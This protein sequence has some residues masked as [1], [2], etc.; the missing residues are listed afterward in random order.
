MGTRETRFTVAVLLLTS[1]FLHLA[2]ASN[3]SMTLPSTFFGTA[4]SLSANGSVALVVG[5]GKDSAV[6]RQSGLSWSTFNQEG[7]VSRLAVDGGTVSGDG[8][9]FVLAA[10]GSN[11]TQGT[12]YVYRRNGLLWTSEANLT[13]SDSAPSDYF[14]TSVSLSYN[15]SYLLVGSASKNA[16]GA[17]QTGAAYVFSRNGTKWAQQQQLLAS[18]GSAQDLFGKAV[19]L[20][21]DGSYALIG[22]PGVSQSKGAVYAF[23][24]I[25]TTWSEEQKI[26]PGYLVDNDYFGNGVKISSSGILALVSAHGKD[27]DGIVDAGAAY[28][29]TLTAGTWVDTQAITASN[30]N[31]SNAFGINNALAISDD[32]SE[33]LVGAPFRVNYDTN[34]LGAAY[35]YQYNGTGWNESAILWNPQGNMTDRFGFSVAVSANNSIAMVGAPG[36]TRAYVFYTP[37]PSASPTMTPTATLSSFYTITPNSTRSPS[38]SQSISPSI[39][40]SISW[41]ASN[42]QTGTNSRTVS[43]SPSVTKS[44][45]SISVSTSF[46]RTVSITPSFSPTPSRTRTPSVIPSGVTPSITPSWS[47]SYN[48]TSSVTPSISD[49]ASNSKS[50]SWSRTISVS[51]SF[52]RSPTL[53]RTTSRTPSFTRSPSVTVTP[54][55]QYI[56]VTASLD[57]Q[58]STE[59]SVV[60]TLEIRGTN[61]YAGCVGGTIEQTWTSASLTQMLSCNDTYI[62]AL[63]DITADPLPWLWVESVFMMYVGTTGSPLAQVVPSFP[64]VSING[65][66]TTATVAWG[67]VIQID[68]FGIGALPDLSIILTDVGREQALPCVITAT[69]SNNS[70]ACQLRYVTSS[71]LGGAAPVVVAQ[72]GGNTLSESPVLPLQL[73]FQPVYAVNT[74]HS[75]FLPL[76]GGDVMTIELPQPMWTSQEETDANLQSALAVYVGVNKSTDCTATTPTQIT[77]SS[78]GG[79]GVQLPVV[80]EI[81][82]I[83]NVSTNPPLLLSYTPPSALAITPV[84]VLVRP[85]QSNVQ[86]NLTFRAQFDSAVDLLLLRNF[87][88]SNGT[89]NRTY[90][91]NAYVICIGWNP[92]LSAFSSG[93]DTLPLVVS[94]NWDSSVF[95][96]APLG[97]AILRPSISSVAPASVTPSGILVLFG[98]NMCPTG[99]CRGPLDVHVWIGTYVCSSI[100]VVTSDVLTCTVPAV[101]TSDPSFPSFAVTVENVLGARSYS[102]IFVSFPTSGSVQPA[103]ALPSTYM[104]SDSSTPWAMDQE[105]VVSLLP[106]GDTLPYHGDIT[107]S[108]TTTTPGALLLPI[109]RT[110]LN[111]VV[112]NT[113]VRFGRVGIQTQFT[114]LTVQLIVS[115]SSVNTDLTGALSLVWTV[116]TVPLRVTMCIEP[117]TLIASQDTI[118]RWA[119]G[120]FVEGSATATSL[121]CMAAKPRWG[122]PALPPIACVASVIDS[123]G[124]AGLVQGNAAEVNVTTGIATFGSMSIA[125][126]INDVYTVLVR[127]S[128]GSILIPPTLTRTVNITGCAAGAEPAGVFCAPC[129]AGQYG[130]GGGKPC[131]G[132]PRKGAVCNDGMLHLLQGYYRPPQYA[133]QDLDS[134]SELH[135]CALPAGCVTNATTR[136]FGCASG[137]AGVL[138]G[139]CAVEDGYGRVADACVTCPPPGEAKFVVVVL[140]L[141]IVL[142]VGCVAAGKIGQE[143]PQKAGAPP[144][145][146][147]VSIALRMLLTHVQAVGSLHS[148]NASGTALYH[149]LTAWADIMSSTVLAQGPVQCALQPTYSLVFALTILAPFVAVL[150]GMAA[151]SVRFVFGCVNLRTRTV[152]PRAW[153]AAWDGAWAARRPL[154]I[155]LVV[156]QV[157]YMPIV[158]TAFTIF[159]CTSP[160]AGEQYLWADLRVACEGP[161]YIGL[162]FGAVLALLLLG[163]GFPLTLFHR[164]SHATVRSLA[165]PK[166]QRVWGFLYAG[167]RARPE[168]ESILNVGSPSRWG[169]YCRKVRRNLVWWEAA[170]LLRKAGIVLM[171]RVVHSDT[172]QVVGVIF[173][174]MGFLIAQVAMRPYTLRTFH[175]ADAASM[176]TIIITAGL[177]LLQVNNADST[178]ADSVTIIMVVINILMVLAL[179]GILYRA[180]KQEWRASKKR[181]TSWIPN[182]KGKKASEQPADL[183]PEVEPKLKRVFS[184]PKLIDNGLFKMRERTGK[185]RPW[186]AVSD[187]NAS[188]EVVVSSQIASPIFAP[189]GLPSHHMSN[190]ASPMVANPFFAAPTT[191]SPSQQGVPIALGDP[192]HPG[193][194]RKAADVSF[195]GPL[196]PRRGNRIGTQV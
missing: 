124:V 101:D 62:L 32:G 115:C 53:T 35:L 139:T 72:Y 161:V 147:T 159:D 54:N 41:S 85:F 144:K 165:S 106:A 1:A 59:S 118:P 183:E 141:V 155:L 192:L 95:S 170:V 30:A 67:N 195:G 151:L 92:A 46:S 181:R 184:L 145:T 162:Q 61:L 19:S 90:V 17:P 172:G 34:K 163:V 148:F 39:S 21:W 103:Q 112:N 149:K 164:L 123:D 51:Q 131:L 33:V 40:K 43:V 48:Q 128:V 68:A 168:K 196:Q 80:W 113:Y 105:I 166:F 111:A 49:T 26:M 81:D 93:L 75:P 6:Y 7:I 137:Y 178:E 157:T 14:G 126:R 74:T 4:V 96:S 24:R 66:G 175:L 64:S 79:H 156:C 65:A 108:L 154:A 133:A 142:L 89:C 119:V 173:M 97:Q 13:G 138:C 94:F 83:L 52:S 23:S 56:Y 78:P 171:A 91:E 20:N 152:S 76:P 188:T 99:W 109:T 73:Q 107:C 143:E 185:A 134:A 140:I 135:A 179:L 132:C 71:M 122:G 84:T 87:S 27:V 58:A 5:T 187:F 60:A 70:V 190:N 100:Q 15:A 50:I 82:G 57:E 77:C 37:P 104:P 193:N 8:L 3:V 136:S 36:T 189:A 153:L 174:M 12:V 69:L 127:C 10:P 160:I 180:A 44:P 116:V 102:P 121:S 158:S 86:N 28:I 18:D 22:A 169:I 130:D 125:G 11:K 88:I 176:S 2:H 120:I 150:I 129:A 186:E 47:P 191:E 29:Y 25:G 177:A 55:I 31:A 42:T 146:R 110:D 194:I 182:L 9:R 167:Y 98:S 114:M 38:V 16:S 117:G 45:P 63:Y